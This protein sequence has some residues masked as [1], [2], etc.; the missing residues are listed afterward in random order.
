MMQKNITENQRR[1]SAR[2]NSITITMGEYV[3]V[4]HVKML[5]VHFESQMHAK[6]RLVLS[7]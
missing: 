4:C 6:F 3:T 1:L 5:I 7:R 2:K